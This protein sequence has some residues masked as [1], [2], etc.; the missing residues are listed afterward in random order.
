MLW[1]L[2]LTPHGNPNTYFSIT[3]TFK[4][5]PFRIDSSY[6][7]IFSLIFSLWN[8]T[9]N[10]SFEKNQKL[11]GNKFG[12]YPTEESTCSVTVMITKYTNSFNGVSMV[13][14]VTPWETVYSCRKVISDTYINTIQPDL[15]IFN[16]FI[17]YVQEGNLWYLHQDCITKSWY[18]QNGWVHSEQAL[19]S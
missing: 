16:I 1:S 7:V 6:L 11:Q 12:L 13:N 14:W 5:S 19:S 9:G 4:N 2:L 18:I 17:S 8:F 10:F 15:E 3:S